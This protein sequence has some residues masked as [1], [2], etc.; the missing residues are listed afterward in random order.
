MIYLSRQFQ[1]FAFV[2]TVTLFS[3][4][5]VA[6]SGTRQSAPDLPSSNSVQTK[7]K[8]AQN[9]HSSFNSPQA[10]PQKGEEAL[11]LLKEGTDL[12]RNGRYD[13]A[14]VM[15]E[16]SLSLEPHSV[17]A[18]NNLG[19]VLRNI[20]RL[21]KALAAYERAISMDSRFALTY[22]NLGILQEKRGEKMQAVQAYRKYCELSPNAAD[23]SIV[24]ERAGWLE[25]KR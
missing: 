23:V 15:L 1:I 8:G 20:G 11:R 4:V 10:A 19:V 2:L 5:Q 17:V 24:A 6:S 3:S 13:Q 25:G 21:D 16:K 18:L 9:T 22:K 14:A 7:E 12:A